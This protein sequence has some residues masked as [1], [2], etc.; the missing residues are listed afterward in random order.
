[1]QRMYQELCDVDDTAL[2]DNEFTCHLVTM[3][4]IS[5]CWRYLHSELLNKDCGAA[6]GMLRSS[7]ILGKLRDEDEGIQAFNDEPS[8]LM[9]AWAEFL[10]SKSGNKH[11]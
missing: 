5:D 1:M 3:M 6:P 4:P 8:V 9:T 2:P 10:Q 11:P 7:E